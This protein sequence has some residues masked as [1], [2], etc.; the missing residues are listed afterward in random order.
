MRR[1]LTVKAAG[2]ALP[3]VL[4]SLRCPNSVRFGLQVA[5]RGPTVF[6]GSA[7]VAVKQAHDAAS[8]GVV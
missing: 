1:S 6:V 4:G 5:D 2:A 3:M 7:A 8:Y